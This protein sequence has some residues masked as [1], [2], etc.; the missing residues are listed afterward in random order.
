[1]TVVPVKVG[2]EMNS[3][4]VVSSGGTQVLVGIQVL[5]NEDDHVSSDWNGIVTASAV[6]DDG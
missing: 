6:P 3:A 4:F 2:V 5:K 1:M